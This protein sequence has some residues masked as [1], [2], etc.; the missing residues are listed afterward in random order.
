MR[1]HIDGVG[2]ADPVIPRLSAPSLTSRH[3]RPVSRIRETVSM[4]LDHGV[5]EFTDAGRHQLNARNQTVP[6]DVFHDS[7]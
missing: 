5:S 6:L 2:V 4:G 1:L 3:G 7:L